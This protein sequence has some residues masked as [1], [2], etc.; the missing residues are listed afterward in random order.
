MIR[1]LLIFILLLGSVWLGIQLHQ[2]T[3]YV[4]VALNH[5]TLESTVLTMFITLTLIFL[6]LH[7]S[8]ITLHWVFQ[9]P[10]RWRCWRLKRK[11]KH[12]LKQKQQDKLREIHTKIA[13]ETTPEG[14]F[15]LGQLLDELNDPKGANLAYKEGLKRALGI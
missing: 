15:T 11:A 6:V 4:L 12:A 2:D 5:W 9:L 14:Y 1:T 10:R 8:L 3:G 7:V 13:L